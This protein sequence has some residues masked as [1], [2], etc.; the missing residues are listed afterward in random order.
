MLV[1][2][3]QMNYS[4]VSGP[5]YCWLGFSISPK[6]AAIEAIR[7]APPGTPLGEFMQVSPERGQPVYFS[8]VGILEEIGE[9]RKK[10][11]QPARNR[12][13]AIW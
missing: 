13:R 1:K 4:V 8:T 7:E 2:R 3:Q 12:V 5:S 9:R 11:L 10:T 6:E